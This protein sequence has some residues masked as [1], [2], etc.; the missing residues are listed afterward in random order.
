[1]KCE[2]CDKE[3]KNRN[4]L[5]QHEIRC[6]KNPN[7][8]KTNHSEETKKK[9]ST[10]MKIVNS[11]SKRVWKSETINKLKKSS[12]D[13][14]EKYWSDEKRKEHSLLMMSVIKENPNSY[15]VNNVSGRAK[16]IEYNGKKLKGNWELFIAKLLD[17]FDIKWTN[18]IKP[19]PYFWNNTWHLYFPDFYL[20][21]YDK[22]IE[23]KGYERERDR[24]KWENVKNLIVI[25]E[26]DIDILKINEDKIFEIING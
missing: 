25:K 16:I 5:I 10:V 22:Y 6:Q 21:D 26:K 1:M 15:S 4:S 23:V 13:F 11:N 8:I 18:D 17:N 24:K 12:K 19:I 2:H 20:T 14:N 3:C 9:L 7:K